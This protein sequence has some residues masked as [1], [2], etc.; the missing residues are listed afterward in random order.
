MDPSKQF[1]SMLLTEV[2]CEDELTGCSPADRGKQKCKHWV[3]VDTVFPFDG[4][5]TVSVGL[6]E[7]FSAPQPGYGL[8]ATLHQ[9]ES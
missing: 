9:G 6:D 2:P 1:G 4:G 7:D 3:V 5:T 8:G